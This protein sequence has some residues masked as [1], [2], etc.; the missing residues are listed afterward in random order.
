MWAALAVML[1]TGDLQPKTQADIE[2]AMKDWLA[3]RDLHVGDT[4]V[5]GRARQL[6][7][8]LQEAE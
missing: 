4:A 1:Y 3:A 7:Q 8:K 6:W 2:R 5:R